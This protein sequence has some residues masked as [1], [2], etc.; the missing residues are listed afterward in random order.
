M[1]IGAY[2]VI[3]C[4]GYFMT[5]VVQFYILACLIGLFQ[6]GIQ[7][8][9]RSYFTRFVP[10]GQEAQFFGFYNMLGKF[11]AI[12]GPLLVG[13]VTLATGS[14]RTGILSLVLLFLLGGILLWKVD[15]EEGIRATREYEAHTR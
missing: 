5:N 12:I 4:I 1:A 9:S 15:E 8:M 2:A 3:T 11:A 7:A 10:A 13:V 6:G 14:H